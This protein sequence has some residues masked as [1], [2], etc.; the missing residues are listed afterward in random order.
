MRFKLKPHPVKDEIR[1]IRKF[2]WFP[3]RIDLER[4]WL[5]YATIEYV[6]EYSFHEAW[7]SARKFID[8]PGKERNIKI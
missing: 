5:E 3:L 4:R 2:L 8:G 6:Y 7:W 1:I